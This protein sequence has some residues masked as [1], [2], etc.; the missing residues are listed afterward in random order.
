MNVA[1]MPV[2]K[3]RPCH[4]HR[5]TVHQGDSENWIYSRMRIPFE[6]F[7]KH[8]GYRTLCDRAQHLA[9]GANMGGRITIERGIT[10]IALIVALGGSATAANQVES[11]ATPAASPMASPLAS[12]VGTAGD[13]SEITVD[14][15]SP[16]FPVAGNAFHLLEPG[17]PGELSVVAHGSVA[18]ALEIPV[19][20]RNNTDAPIV[21]ATV[22]VE[23]RDASGLLIGEAAR[24]N[25]TPPVIEPGALAIAT[26]NG[27]QPLP[28]G[29]T[30]RYY[31]EGNSDPYFTRTFNS[32]SGVELTEFIAF[33]ERLEGRVRSVGDAAIK[34]EWLHFACWDTSGKL[35]STFFT[36]GGLQNLEPDESTRF[37]AQLLFTNTAPACDFFLV[38]GSGQ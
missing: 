15:S 19:I 20:L 24:T 7:D 9:M 28:D 18:G 25:V 33:P 37:E 16:R 38:T 32:Y 23:V 3:P 11:G 30:V 12:P 13:A 21:L 8:V 36:S 22:R 6:V 1:L 5:N 10:I 2:N 29:E 27:D 31:P 14:V 35:V 26:I 34:L 4:H 17:T